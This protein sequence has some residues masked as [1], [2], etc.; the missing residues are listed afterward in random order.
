VHDYEADVKN[1]RKEREK[2]EKGK[3]NEFQR[4]VHL[5]SPLVKKFLSPLD[6]P[7]SKI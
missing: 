1:K 7:F 5:V 4:S 3:K 2:K 6:N